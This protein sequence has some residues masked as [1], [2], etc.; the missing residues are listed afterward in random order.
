MEKDK[1]NKQIIIKINVYKI[2]CKKITYII[3]NECIFTL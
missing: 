3:K 1:I 2:E